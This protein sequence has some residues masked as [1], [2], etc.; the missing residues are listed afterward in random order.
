MK[1]GVLAE[2]MLILLKSHS[3]VRQIYDY[4]HSLNDSLGDEA[5]VSP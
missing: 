2:I 4:K 3:L 5:N 1:T